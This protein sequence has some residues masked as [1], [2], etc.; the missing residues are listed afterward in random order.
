VDLDAF[1][2]D[3][4]VAI[5]GAFDADTA[6]A[7]RHLI[8]ESMGQ[9]RIYEDDPGTWPPQADIDDLD[10]EPFRATATAPARRC[11]PRGGRAFPVG[12]PG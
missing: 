5:R 10:N 2:R 1:I 8:W 12:G 7:L 9:Q 4:Y 6:A 3:G 11:R